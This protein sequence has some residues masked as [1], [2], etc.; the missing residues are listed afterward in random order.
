MRDACLIPGLGRSPGAGNSN[1]F[2]YSFL[3]NPMARG[4]WWATVCGAADSETWLS[5][6]ACMQRQMVVPY[7]K[8]HT[9]SIIKTEK[10]IK[11]N[12]NIIYY[13]FFLK[14]T[15]N[16]VYWRI[17]M[18]FRKMVTITLYARQRKRHRCIEQS[19]GLCGRG[20]GR[21]DTGEWHWNM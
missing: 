13:L 4:G 7:M 10:L 20:Q 3:G 2:S 6:R 5:M 9:I 14:N 16:T 12:R 8:T 17:Y 21:D 15:T 18:E 11:A 19:F 1:P